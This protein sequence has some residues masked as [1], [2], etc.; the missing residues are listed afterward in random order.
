MKPIKYTYIG[1]N[2]IDKDGCEWP[3]KIYGGLE[4][5]NGE[6]VELREPFATKAKLNPFFELA[7]PEKPKF[8]EISKERPLVADKDN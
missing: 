2:K 5:L 1:P 4:A 7:K 3:V 8:K 6:V